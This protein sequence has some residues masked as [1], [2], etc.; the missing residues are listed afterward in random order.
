MTE[1][2]LF[3]SLTLDG[4][5]PIIANDTRYTLSTLDFLDAGGDGYTMF[6]A[7]DGGSVSRD[8]MAAILEEHLRTQGTVTPNTYD[9][10]VNVNN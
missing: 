3:R 6:A 2:R 5:T 10:I 1:R 9:R 8:K 7:G 4:G